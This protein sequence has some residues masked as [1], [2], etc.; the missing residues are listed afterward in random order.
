MKASSFCVL[1]H[2]WCK[3]WIY[4]VGV[5]YKFCIYTHPCK[6]QIYNMKLV[7]WCIKVLDAGQKVFKRSDPNAARCWALQKISRFKLCNI[8]F[9]EI[10]D[11]KTFA[12]IMKYLLLHLNASKFIAS[13]L[14]QDTRATVCRLLLSIFRRQNAHQWFIHPML[15]SISCYQSSLITSVFS[16][17][18]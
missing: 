15:G 16:F 17:E 5:C 4:W 6:F 8:D 11:L 2:S 12:S 7:W 1:L 13:R 14:D 18:N 10:L 9:F 3:F